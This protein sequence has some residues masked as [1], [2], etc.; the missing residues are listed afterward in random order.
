MSA[1]LLGGLSACIT[2]LAIVVLAAQDKKRLGSARSI[3]EKRRSPSILVLLFAL[4][5]GVAFIVFGEWVSFLIW[6]GASAVLG[7]LV[8]LFWQ[9]REPLANPKDDASS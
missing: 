9:H 8:A 6:I 4:V 3:E 1:T 7:W 2:L 5:P